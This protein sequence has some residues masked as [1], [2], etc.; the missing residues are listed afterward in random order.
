MTASSALKLPPMF[1]PVLLLGLAPASAF[2]QLKPEVQTGS[3]IPVKPE[4]VPG[5]EAGLIKKAFGRCI[6]ESN[7]KAAA[8]ILSHSDGIG[9]DLQ[10]AKITDLVQTFKMRDCLGEQVSETQSAL[11]FRFGREML[12][13]LLVEETYLAGHPTA[14]TLAAGAVEVIDRT[15][16]SIGDALPKARALG[17]FA[18]CIVFTDVTGSD[19]LLR[20]IPGSTGE[21]AAARALV[22]ALSKCLNQGA[23]LSMTP[24][25]IRG[26]VADGLWNR[27]SRPESVQAAAAAK[28]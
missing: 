3:H 25:S 18:D 28:P 12:H 13:G 15:Y 22:P 4:A 1:L 21:R 27:F 5:R 11:G 8:A 16:V 9:I 2:G 23:Q 6:Y 17:A 26:Y 24:A 20:T 10:S 7:K 19:A 14:P